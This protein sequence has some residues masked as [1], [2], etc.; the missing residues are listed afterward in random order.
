LRIAVIG[1]NGQLGS[2]ICQRFDPDFEV[3]GLTHEQIEISNIDNVDH[4]IKSIKP[5]IVL[6]TAAY[7]NVPECEKNPHLAFQVNTIGVLNLV[8]LANE[9]KYILVHFSTDYV[10]DGTK[11]SPYIEDDI[12]NPLNIYALSKL[13]GETIIK[14]YCERYF[15]LRIAGIYG[16]T[17]CR[18][19]GG[20][21]IHTMIR[22]AK[23][24]DIVTV[25]ND[26]ILSPTSVY[27]IAVHLPLLLNTDA[28][29]L[30]HFVCH[31]ACSWYDFASVIFD[32]LKLKTPLKSCSSDQVPVTI[33]RPRYSAL[34]NHNLSSLKLDTLAYWKEALIK[35]LSDNFAQL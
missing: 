18:A 5:D 7:H 10:F 4:I 30:Y 27:E 12:P 14:N 23:E 15:V 28:Y 24:R 13:N 3:I 17:P 31:G 8:K 29:G 20:N 32:K 33:K 9:M 21:F 6:N 25:V 26:E 11:N 16:K 35:F 34:E 2:E 22:A 19:K 1:A